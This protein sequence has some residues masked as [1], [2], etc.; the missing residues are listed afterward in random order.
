MFHIIKEKVHARFLQMQAQTLLVVGYDRDL[1]WQ[2][3]LEQFP[4]ETRQEHTC[5]ACKSFI[6]QAGAAVTLDPVT[7]KIGTIWDVTDVPE[8]YAASIKALGDY[9]RSLP[10]TGLY[11]HTEGAA[12]VDKNIDKVRS[13][14]L[15]AERNPGASAA[16]L[17]RISM[18]QPVVWQHFYAKIPTAIR[19]VDG[20]MVRKSAKLRE[21]KEMLKRA[22]EEI[23]LSDV[24]LVLELI[25]QGSLLR[26][27]EKKHIVAGARSLLVAYADVPLE[28]RENWCWNAVSTTV[29]EGMAR[30]RND[31]IGTLLVDLAEGKELEKAVYAF[32]NKVNGGNY[33][34]PTALATPKMIEA[35][36]QR[37]IDLGLM[38]SLARRRLDSRDL[39]VANA[40]HVY[41]PT[42]KP[43]GDVFA[44]I[45]GEVAV[46]PK[47]LSKVE[48]IP[49]AKFLSDVLPNA[50]SLK[51]LFEREHMNKLVTLTGPQE[52][53]SE[54]L[55]KW[56]NNFGW[57]YTG[58]VADSVKERV[59]AKGGKVDAW[60]RISLSWY[61]FDDLD[62]HFVGQGQHVYYGNK[63]SATLNATLDVD[64]NAGHGSSRE[65]VENIHIT[66]PL[67]AGD[68]EVHVVNFSK[69]ESRDV[70]FEVETE[71]NGELLTFAS[72]TS[73]AKTTDIR[74]TVTKDGQV[75]FKDTKMSKAGS[76]APGATKWGM[77][78][79]T[80][81]R[82][83][84]V[85]LSPNHWTRP[86]GHKHLFFLLEG[87]VSDE[88][89]RPFFNEQLRSEFVAERKTMEMIGGRLEVAVA[90][91]PELSGVG[92]SDE[93]RAHA[94]IEVEGQFTRI[95]KVL[96]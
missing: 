19:D 45:S 28:Q 13:E 80:W 37:L 68:Y 32:E 30:F 16:A 76:G 66:R 51:L 86:D 17:A 49:L 59:K 44:E 58:N 63:R 79:G 20:S 12:G 6:R 23:R 7:L 46:N 72:Q 65:A 18:E 47:T 34:R 41:R 82:V 35:A 52:S 78:T 1:I 94:Y 64:M 39:T 84:A 14:N 8:E 5:N 38:S 77:K 81:R 42:S 27:N 62:L 56:D 50:K 15:A 31:V 10:I 11:F 85:T 33:Q 95:V 60:G 73:P 83:S 55:F 3:Y 61:N 4:E 57:S 53:E 54:N 87:C 24:D 70:G 67:A 93:H 43:V 88:A 89:T 22:L 9:V 36:K 69:R 92:F 26:G 25:S 75:I 74:F 29:T 71:I 40:L 90:D 96:F 21:G 2:T 48:E 91:G